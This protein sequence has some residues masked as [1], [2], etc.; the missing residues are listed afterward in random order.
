MPKRTAVR[1]FICQEPRRSIG[2]WVEAKQDYRG[3][4]GA[5]GPRDARGHIREFLWV[6]LWTFGAWPYLY[7][8]SV[9][10]MCMPGHH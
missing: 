4:G 5:E 10:G 3:V 7:G 1:S 8:G 2:L 9:I 6:P